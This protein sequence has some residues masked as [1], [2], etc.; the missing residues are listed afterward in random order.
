MTISTRA[1]LIAPEFG[2]D[3]R[4]MAPAIAHSSEVKAVFNGFPAAV[5][6]LCAEVDGV[7]HGMVATSLAVG[8]S[9]D[10]PM[11]MFS[12]RN[13][14]STWPTLRKAGRIGISVLAANQGDV[15]RQI[16][17]KDGNRFDGLD[18]SI[19]DQ[20]SLFIGGAVTWMDCEIVGE[21]PAGDHTVI[22]FGV[23]EVSH[24]RQTPPLVFHNGRFPQLQHHDS[25]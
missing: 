21:L 11:V 3:V 13:D 7:P 18:A 17:A 9:Y 19:S 22:T 14:S 2:N 6:A 1:E 23:H 25:P 10:P 16:A 12:V 4:T 8:V 5:G 24:C 20:G 15:C